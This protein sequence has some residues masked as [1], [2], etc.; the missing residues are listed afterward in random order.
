[1]YSDYACDTIQSM[2]KVTAE[3]LI[4]GEVVDGLDDWWVEIRLPGG[5]I[6]TVYI[7]RIDPYTGEKDTDWED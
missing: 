1:M 3:E 4:G 6:V 7:D 5:R 2:D